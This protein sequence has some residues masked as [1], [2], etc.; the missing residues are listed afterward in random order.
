M[1]SRNANIGDIVT[2]VSSSADAK[3]S[4]L[5][6]ADMSTLEVNA[7]VSEASLAKIKVGQPCEITLDAFPERR[8][9]GEVS[10]VV[11][12]VNRSSA[13]VTTK[14]RILD[15]DPSILPDMSARVSF[16]SQRVDAEQNKPVLAVNPSALAERGGRRVVYVPDADL[17][18]EVPVTTGATL[19]AVVA[20]EGALKVGDTVVLEPG[21]IVNGSRIKLAA[22]R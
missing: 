14:V 12:A 5:E 7:D 4:L 9:R 17:A 6:L 16:L 13:T 2:P 15:T 22:E 20:V 3:G 11:P 18:R 21:K 19:G 1:I 10:V 8:F